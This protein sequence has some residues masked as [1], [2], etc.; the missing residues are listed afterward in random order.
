MATK[1]NFLPNGIAQISADGEYS[2]KVSSKLPHRFS[3]VDGKVVD[4][5]NGISDEEVVKAD[6]A[7]AVALATEKGEE[8]PP[9]PF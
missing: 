7:A 5:Y 2:V 8:P 1:L 3:L 9:Q 4:K 6:F